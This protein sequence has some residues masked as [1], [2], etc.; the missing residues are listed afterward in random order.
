MYV[1]VPP[2][3]HSEIVVEAINAKKHVLCEKPMAATLEDATKMF[4]ALKKARQASICKKNWAYR[5]D[6]GIVAAINFPMQ[7][8]PAVYKCRDMINSGFIGE[9][10]RVELVFRFPNW[11]RAWQP[12]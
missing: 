8:V 6:A 5:L 7:Y 10:R 11:P 1:G 4:N 12:V 9:V 2:L 3:Y